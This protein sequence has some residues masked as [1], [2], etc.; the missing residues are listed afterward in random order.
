M[1]LNKN[2][3]QKGFSYNF[4]FAAIT[5]GAY[6]FISVPPFLRTPLRKFSEICHFQILSK[7]VMLAYFELIEIQTFAFKYHNFEYD[8]HPEGLFLQFSSL[9]KYFNLG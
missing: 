5:S 4:W 6:K 3:I 7:N 2:E 9:M 1:T 8:F